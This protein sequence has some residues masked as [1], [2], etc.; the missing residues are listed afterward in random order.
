[1]LYY[2]KQVSLS[3]GSWLLLLLSCL[4]FEATGLYFQHVM[5]LEPCVMC[6]YERVAIA[7]VALAALIGMV[8]PRLL[9]I[10]LLALAVGLASAVKGLLLALQHTDYQLN[11]VPW[12]QCP[13]M[14]E[15]PSTLPLNKWLPQ[16]FEA[17][18]SCS[19]IQW[20]LLGFAM[21]QWLIAIF[22]GYIL[23]LGLVLISQIKPSR[24]QR[25]LFK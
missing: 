4:A 21:P 11:P 15:F 3:R 24:R 1:M 8:A 9:L 5:K 17:Y 2:L 6:I 18:G 14:V 13:L 10:R 20:S 12:N 19:E 25:T 23:V 22:I 7:G 16:M